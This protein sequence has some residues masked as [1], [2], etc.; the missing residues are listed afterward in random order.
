MRQLDRYIFDYGLGINM[1][2]LMANRV[3]AVM[4]ARCANQTI[5]EQR[6]T[7]YKISKSYYAARSREA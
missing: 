1:I 2:E 6:F 5:P 3:A 7:Y 4:G